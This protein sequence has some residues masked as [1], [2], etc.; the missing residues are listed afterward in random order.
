MRQ[1]SHEQKHWIWL[2]SIAEAA[3]KTFYSILKVFGSAEA[4]FDAVSSGGDI[5]EVPEKVR[6]SCKGVRFKTVHCR[7]G[8]Y[9]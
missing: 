1:Y 4:F 7:I 8:V 5:G 6:T 2:G 9:A 3:P